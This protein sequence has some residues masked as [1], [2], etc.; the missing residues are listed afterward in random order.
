MQSALVAEDYFTLLS[1]FQPGFA[2]VLLKHVVIFHFILQRRQLCSHCLSDKLTRSQGAG[3]KFAAAV[4]HKYC[5]AAVAMAG[6]L[7]P[8]PANR[9]LIRPA[10]NK[11]VHASVYSASCTGF[12]DSFRHRSSRVVGCWPYFDEGK[13]TVASSV[14]D[15]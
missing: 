11:A 4:P 5:Q 14:L 6:D 1:T 12:R 9:W 15:L 13:D 3:H 7:T 8:F 2:K 10:C